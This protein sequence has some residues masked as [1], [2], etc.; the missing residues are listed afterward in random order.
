MRILR[1]RNTRYLGVEEKEPVTVFNNQT[2]LVR[3]CTIQ[4]N[5]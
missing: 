4:I 1:R 5:G 3:A 2:M